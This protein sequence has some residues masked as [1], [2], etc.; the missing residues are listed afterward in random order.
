MDDVEQDLKYDGHHRFYLSVA[1][2]W[3][4]VFGLIRH[5]DFFDEVRDQDRS[6]FNDSIIIRNVA[7]HLPND[8]IFIG[9][10]YFQ[11]GGLVVCPDKCNKG[12]S[13][14]FQMVSTK[15]IRSPRIVN[16]C[17]IGPI[18]M[19]SVFCFEGGHY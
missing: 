5:I 13:C 3:V 12:L 7:M 18:K 6:I 4:D 17:V 16:K 19:G 14:G 15:D 8:R 2:V 1:L 9:D 10:P 11:R